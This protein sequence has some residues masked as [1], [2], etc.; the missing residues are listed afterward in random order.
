M[1]QRSL[2]ALFL[3]AIVSLSASATALADSK[4]ACLSAASKAQTLRSAH[5]LVE[6]RDQL[7]LCAAAECPAIVHSDCVPW[8]AEVERALPG[9]VVTAKSGGGTDLF[10]VR[11]SVDG[12]LL[13]SK[14]D[15]QAVTMNAG[16]HTFHFETAD[17]TTLDQQV[18]VREGDKS[19]AVAVVLGALRAPSTAT[20]PLSGPSPESS[21]RWR[22]IGW[23]AGGVGLAGLGVGAVFGGIAVAD[24]GAAHCVNNVCDPGTLD[25][26]KS[27]A[28]ASTVGFVAGGVLLAGGAAL[29]LFA[30]HGDGASSAAVTGGVRLVPVLSSGGGQ[31]MAVGTF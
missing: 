4:S 19:Q 16:P 29:V 3:P 13:L 18:L 1:Y 21:G 24:K 10:D 17:G 20:A 26:M 30:P 5:N 6:A 23:I 15:G 31:F 12:Q 28:T 9:V 22:T 14:L 8:L 7:R 25:G 11:V 2:V 27:A